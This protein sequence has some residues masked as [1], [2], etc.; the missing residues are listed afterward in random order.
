MN[1][2]R[3]FAKIWPILSGL[4]LCAASPHL[5][6]TPLIDPQATADRAQASA[7][8]DKYDYSGAIAEYMKAY[9]LDRAIGSDD[10]A[11]DLYYA[12]YCSV[13]TSQYKKAL[14]YFQEALPTLKQTGNAKGQAMVLSG[15]GGAYDGLSQYE[16][17][18]S[19]YDQALPIDEQ[20]G[21]NLLRGRTLNNIAFD[22]DQLSQYSKSLD[23]FEQSLEINQQTDDKAA[24]ATTLSNIGAVY[25]NLG[26]YPKALDLYQQALPLRQQSG[27]LTGTAVTLSNIGAI[28]LETGE[29]AKAISYFKQALPIEKKVGDRL[30]E[31]GT[32]SNIGIAYDDM[33]E[34]PT[35]LNYYRQAMQIGQQIGSKSLI[36]IFTSNI[37]QV[38]QEQGD[39]AKA[40]NYFNQSL[41][42]ARQIG[43][44]AGEAATLNNIGTTNN[45][46]SQYTTALVFLQEALPIE[47]QIG[48]ITR[49]ATTLNNIGL[50]YEGLSQYGKSL[51]YLQQAL[52]ILQQ[53][54]DKSGQ[55]ITL[56]NMG[57]IYIDLGQYND[58]LNFF[59]QALPINQQ[60]GHKEGEA[61]VRNNIGEVY[62]KLGQS[63]D[64]LTSYQQALAIEQ[65]VGNTQ[66]EASTLNNIGWTY[67]ELGQY[68]K[69]VDFY[70]KAL[71]IVDTTGDKA[72][73]GL[74]LS[75]IG[76]VYN[77][78]GQYSKAV[79]YYERALPVEQ[80]IGNTARQAIALSNMM[81]A[82]ASLGK[83]G[84]AIF[85]GK[86]AVN[87]IQ[88][89]RKNIAS[90]NQDSQKSYL[91]G[92]T[93]VY[94]G[95]ADLLI[96]QGRLPEAQQVL[97]LL[98][99]REFYDFLNPDPNAPPP[100]MDKVVLTPREAGWSAAYNTAVQ[101]LTV[102][103]AKV[104][105]RSL[106]QERSPAED[107]QLAAL[108][109]QITHV[110]AAI[111]SIQSK[112]SADFSGPLAAADR[113][114]QTA[115]VQKVQSNLPTGTVVLYTIVAPDRLDLI[116]ITSRGQKAY[117][118]AIAASDLYSDVFT[119]RQALTNPNLDPRPASAVLYNLVLKPIEKDLIAEGAKTILFSL[120]DAL[121]Y[122]PPAVLYN[123][124]TRQYVAQR[125]QTELITLDGPASTIPTADK[126][127]I[128]GLGVSTS[129]DGEPAL[130]GVAQELKAIV[131]E[132][133]DPGGLLPGRRLLDGKF[134]Q[135]ALED[136]LRTEKYPIV[137]IA[138]HFALHST[139][140]TS[141]L[142]LGDGSHLS[143]AD[144]AENPNRFQGVDLLT[145]SACQTAMEV[146]GSNGHEVE[147]IADL[148]QKLGAGSVLASLWP[149]SD[150][151]TPPLMTA[152][153]SYHRQHTA[154]SLSE[155]LQAAQLSLLN[156]SAP[157]TADTASRGSEAV[158]QSAEQANLPSFTPNPKAPYAH[159]FY[160][161]AFILIG[162]WK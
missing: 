162:N 4:L 37:G 70:Q 97:R 76:W 146:R 109:T 8:E 92:N 108:Q 116:L 10:S 88:G 28:Y 58:A 51:D 65:S 45:A 154:A 143:I 34:Y 33:S 55:A 120:D 137:H 153:Y 46:F 140:D 142:L 104:Q 11:L 110:N 151:S 111:K 44:K 148:A 114:I 41:Q 99:E 13:L 75:N 36:S 83:P 68:T 18:L 160:W 40:I 12:G 54:G 39:D 61:N 95:L 20:I 78:K 77:C 135:P 134:T 138:S 90:L 144:L 16:T 112:I 59:Q 26:Q 124:E 14:D 82:W 106:N 19:F 100:A 96:S 133:G 52:P 115:D 145:L 87:L 123:P 159:P 5:C 43:D 22:Y 125:Y 69:A 56:S 74:T 132:P 79:D 3:R 129:Q 67:N 66:D 98:K 9:A 89:I 64:A 93:V 30:T 50:A 35:A 86:Q 126:L 102:L 6:A 113:P 117:S 81:S 84:V 48:D 60:I 62:S 139:L 121:R 128:L 1:R 107:V 25:D 24:Q 7:L 156:G 23:F 152:L 136:S 130:P 155:A 2:L 85:Y 73:E 29:Y 17:A 122:V 63:S 103:G 147:G 57:Q 94:R 49:Q 91:A 53:I 47:R 80:Q 158:N 72:D 118:S 157:Q 27:D 71:S 31:A 38:Y 101:P 21:D 161:G 131:H 141:Y 119:L 32:L 150:A 15:I 149:V 105:T 42:T 127:S